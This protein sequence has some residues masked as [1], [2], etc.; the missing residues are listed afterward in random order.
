MVEVRKFTDDRGRCPYDMWLRSLRDVRAKAKNLTR[1]ERLAYGNEGNC[2]GEGVKELRVTVGQGYRV[3]YA[4]DGPTL[5]VLL[6]G[7]S[8]SSRSDDSERAK[9]R[10]RRYHES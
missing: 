6:G 4:W 2:R 3:Y 8:K 9:A 10:W 7:G 1:I 5:V